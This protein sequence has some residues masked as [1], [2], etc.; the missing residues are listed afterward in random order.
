M[1]NKNF[2]VL[3]KI[4]H[5]LF[6]DDALR[7]LD[8]GTI[9]E[10]TDA[11]SC[12]LGKWYEEEGTSQ[13]KHSKSFQNMKAPHELVHNKVNETFALLKDSDILAHR[14]AILN[15][16]T[17]MEKASQELF[18]YMDAMIEEAHYQTQEDID[19]L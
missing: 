1:K 7:Q 18:I 5:I 15:N 16:F 10:H 19:T 6:K 8:K 11:H 13:F 17:E 3:A 4:D 14:V 2:V 12:R 9:K